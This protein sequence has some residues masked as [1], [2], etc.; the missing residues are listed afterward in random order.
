MGATA[1][2]RMAPGQLT[3]G[4][5]EIG[6][7]RCSGP[8]EEGRHTDPHG[9]SSALS[10]E[11]GFQ[12]PDTDAMVGPWVSVKRL[13]ADQRSCALSCCPGLLHP[14]VDPVWPHSFTAVLSKGRKGI[15][16]V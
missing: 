2:L 14:A 5:L 3:S 12:E 15:P 1:G 9:H 13:C 7:K 8:L 10:S 16:D 6:Q 11:G 4:T